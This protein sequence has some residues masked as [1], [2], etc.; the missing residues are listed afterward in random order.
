MFNMAALNILITKNP[1]VATI[2]ILIMFAYNSYD[3]HVIKQ[4]MSAISSA[5]YEMKYKPAYQTIKKG[6]ARLSHEQALAKIDFW[7]TED[8]VAKIVDLE[9]LC[10]E[11]DRK[12]LFMITGAEHKSADYCR[13]LS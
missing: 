3:G 12:F 2:M 13:A 10:E 5:L 4:E 1:A 8:W 11:K 9:K 7:E 6:L